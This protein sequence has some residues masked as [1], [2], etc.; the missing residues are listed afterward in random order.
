MEGS[1]HDSQVVTDEEQ[2]RQGDLHTAHPVPLS[3]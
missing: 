2:V 1:T 3:P